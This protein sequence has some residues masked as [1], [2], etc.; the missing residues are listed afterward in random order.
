MYLRDLQLERALGMGPVRLFASRSR[1]N[2]AL[3][4]PSSL[5]ID[6]LRRLEEKDKARSDARL[7]YDD[8]MEPEMC[9]WS[10]YRV[11]SCTK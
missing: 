1:N 8:G 7:P 10:T 11:F 6:P 3:R 4:L 9:V 2:S 5:G